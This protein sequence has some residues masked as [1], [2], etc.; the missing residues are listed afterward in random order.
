MQPEPPPGANASEVNAWWTAL[1]EDQRNQLITEH[2]PELGNLNGI[3]ASARDQI[4]TA[5]LNDDLAGPEDAVRYRNALQVKQGLDHERGADPG[6]PRPVLLWTYNPEAFAG[7]GSAA[8]AIG[9]P[10][11]A[12]DIAVIVPGAGS[13]VA[14]G[15]LA[16][17]HNGAINVYDQSLAA[18]PGDE[19]SVI[20]W[21]GYDAPQGYDDPRVGSPLSAREAGVQLAQDVNGLWVT[22]DGTPPHVT[23]LGHSY[24]ATTVADA[25]AA[26]GAHANDVILLGSP[27][28]DLAHGANDFHLDGGRVYVG[29]A[30][31]DPVSW[32][33]ESGALPDGLNEALGHPFGRYAGL[34]TDPAGSGFGSIRFRAEVPGHDGLSF[35]DHSH[36]Y[37]LGGGALR[38]MAHIVTG[39]GAALAA[40]NLLAQGRRQP[41]ITTPSEINI[42]G[43]GPIH[44]PHIDTRIPGLPAYIDPEATRPREG[45]L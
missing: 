4:N 7:N 19:L 35:Q 44:L 10:D 26:S 2:P 22:H 3:P 14:N 27:G 43:I 24:G 23:V 37:D 41:H 5:V 18:Y 21:M 39:H 29:S 34:G 6:N 16:G 30:S 20:A 38:S 1:T 12:D 11:R 45:A 32:I 42:P 40:D 33:G 8:I 25:F 17:G 15:W 9:D 36:Y 31:S 28:T 13:S